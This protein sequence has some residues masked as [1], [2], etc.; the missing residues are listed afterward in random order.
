M[1]KGREDVA[2]VEREVSESI[3]EQKKEEHAAAAK[4]QTTEQKLH[5]KQE[6]DSYVKQVE[7]RLAD[8]ELKIDELEERAS[9]SG[10]R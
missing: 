4:L 2:E 3:R 6:R 5:A 9:K 7:H 8:M 1:S 10:R